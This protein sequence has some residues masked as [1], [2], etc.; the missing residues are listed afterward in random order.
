[1]GFLIFSKLPAEKVTGKV[2]VA[3]SAG[4]FEGAGEL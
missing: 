2:P 1:V 4:E 3:G